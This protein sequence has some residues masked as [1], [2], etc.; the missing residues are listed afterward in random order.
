MDTLCL[1]C[2]PLW[3]LDHSQGEN[4]TILLKNKIIKRTA[5]WQ[6]A[7]ESLSTLFTLIL[8]NTC[9]TFRLKACVVGK[10]EAGQIH[11]NTIILLALPCYL[12]VLTPIWAASISSFLWFQV[13]HIWIAPSFLLLE[14][15]MKDPPSAGYLTCQFRGSIWVVNTWRNLFLFILWDSESPPRSRFEYLNTTLM[16]FHILTGMRIRNMPGICQMASVP[17]SPRMMDTISQDLLPK[18]GSLKISWFKEFFSSEFKNSW[19]LEMT[20]RSAN[21]FSTVRL[22]PHHCNS[23]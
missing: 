15:D 16:S 20:H 6:M 1:V 8:W 3:Y 23:L 13:L 12:F 7:W 11:K 22:S 2:M 21:H 5:Y 14:M 17:L 9:C 18:N 19:E 4:A 10:V